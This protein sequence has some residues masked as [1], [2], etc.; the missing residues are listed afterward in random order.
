VLCTMRA[1]DEKS[2]RWKEWEVVRCTKYEVQSRLRGKSR[3]ARNE[4]HLYEVLSTRYKDQK[5]RI[6]VLMRIPTWYLVHCT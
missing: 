6:V 1:V 2:Y 4:T 3:E 5:S